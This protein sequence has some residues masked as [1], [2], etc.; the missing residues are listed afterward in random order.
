MKTV[1]QVML[2][3]KDKINRKFR[4][5]RKQKAHFLGSKAQIQDSL[6]FLSSA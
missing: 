6:V 1:F 4:V 2:T 5:T 3:V